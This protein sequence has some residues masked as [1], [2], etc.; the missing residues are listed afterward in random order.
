MPHPDVH[1]TIPLYTEFGSPYVFTL[2]VHRRFAISYK[3]LQ[4]VSD[5]KSCGRANP[6]LQ[7]FAER[8]VP[9]NVS[10]VQREQDCDDGEKAARGTSPLD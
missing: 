4:F 5:R 7:C 2:G 8:P 10:S 3:R 1:L 6:E 9:N